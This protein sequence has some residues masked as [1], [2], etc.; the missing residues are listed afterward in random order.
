VRGFL[1]SLL[2]L[3]MVLA[4]ARG[5]GKSRK[6]SLG[7]K[8]CFGA[9]RQMMECAAMPHEQST[10]AEILI[11]TDDCVFESRDDERRPGCLCASRAESCDVLKSCNAGGKGERP[12]GRT[13]AV[14]AKPRA[15][16][17]A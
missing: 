6:P 12:S 8:V 3:A 7:K 1:A 10:V 9:C 5:E 15:V 4:A 2:L 14:G 13:P 16:P 11:C 17:G